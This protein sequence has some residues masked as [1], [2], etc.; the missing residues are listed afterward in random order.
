MVPERD[1]STGGESKE[2][3]PV[4][5]I[6]NPT[7]DRVVKPEV[8]ANANVETIFCQPSNGA[9]CISVDPLQAYDVVKVTTER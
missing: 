5:S 4:R 9:R 7:A 8:P 2:N 3:L 6:Y 1:W